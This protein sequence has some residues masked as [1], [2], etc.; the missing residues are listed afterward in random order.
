MGHT[1]ILTE[2]RDEGKPRE[3]GKENE[4]EGDKE[5][6]EENKK[7]WRNQEGFKGRC[8]LTSFLSILTGL[9]GVSGATPVFLRRK[10]VSSGA[11]LLI[12]VFEAL[13]FSISW[14]LGE[15]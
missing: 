4:G 5:G 10:P 6:G 8:P 7:G 13:I 15:G 1:K 3:A 14:S 2:R 9:T 11:S 12:A